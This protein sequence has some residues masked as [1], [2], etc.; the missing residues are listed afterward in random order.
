MLWSLDFKLNDKSKRARTVTALLLLVDSCYVLEEH[1]ADGTPLPC[2]IAACWDHWFR[3]QYCVGPLHIT[4][5]QA[6]YEART[7][8]LISVLRDGASHAHGLNARFRLIS[9]LVNFQ[10]LL[11]LDHSCNATFWDKDSDF[12]KDFYF[13][14]WSTWRKYGRK[15]VGRGRAIGSA[16]RPRL[17]KRGHL[18]PRS[19]NCNVH[20]L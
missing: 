6:R 18:F 20:D 5:F 4:N 1:S 13:G 2:F 7:F 17:V 16:Q 9:E 15:Y 10:L 14:N 8:P 3:H 11:H 12:I 19:R